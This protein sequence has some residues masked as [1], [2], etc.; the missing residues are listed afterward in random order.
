[1]VYTFAPLNKGN[2]LRLPPPIYPI[3]ICHLSIPF[4]YQSIILLHEMALASHPLAQ[5]IHPIPLSHFWN[6]IN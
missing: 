3:P 1:M 4:F 6:K 5:K 2:S